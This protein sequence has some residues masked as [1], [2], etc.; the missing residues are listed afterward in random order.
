MTHAPYCETV[1]QPIAVDF[2]HKRQSGG[3]GE[4]ARVCLTL[5][6]N[7]RGS[8]TTF[9]NQ[10]IQENVPAAY[11]PG[12]EAGVARALEQGVLGPHPVVDVIVTLTDGAYHDVDSSA[13]T[14]ETA[15]FH[16]VKD[17]LRRSGTLLLQAMMRVS[18]SAPE[19]Y[20]PRVLAD[21]E[22]RGAIEMATRDGTVTATAPQAKLSDY[23]A[24]L[25]QLTDGKGQ[26][27]MVF[28]RYVPCLTPPDG[29]GFPPAMGH[30]A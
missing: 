20:H 1:M 29:P 7:T 9:R 12:V 4:F 23:F 5:T 3:A 2:T 19:I 18:V 27:Q 25:H 24:T 10:L 14:F 28:D 6:P 15:A 8:G 21:L 11:I 16:A 22:E 26:Y 17:G 13:M 30:R